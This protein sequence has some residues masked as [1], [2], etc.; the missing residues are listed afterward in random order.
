MTPRWVLCWSYAWPSIGDF[1]NDSAICASVRDRGVEGS[2]PFAPTI[3]L[4]KIA[5]FSPSVHSV[6][7]ANTPR[8]TEC[9][10]L[11]TDL[12]LEIVRDSRRPADR[13]VTSG[14]LLAARSYADLMQ[15]QR[16]LPEIAQQEFLSDLVVRGDAYANDLGPS[17]TAA[18]QTTK[19]PH[20]NAL[21]SPMPY[22]YE[23]GDRQ[24]SNL[25]TRAT[26]Q[27]D[28][29]VGGRACLVNVRAG[30]R[31]VRPRPQLLRRTRPPARPD[32]GDDRSAPYSVAR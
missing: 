10:A 28:A 7:P 27:V 5:E 4:I 12:P 20:T 21:F 13:D 2:N 6:L 1:S 11:Q 9:S 19:P 29:S 15:T 17:G 26:A 31:P 22:L 14:V 16:V 24:Q 32:E 25:Y 8:R 30:V 23:R 3:F 18:D